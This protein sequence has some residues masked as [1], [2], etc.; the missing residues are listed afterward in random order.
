M[1]VATLLFKILMFQILASFVAYSITIQSF[2]HDVRHCRPC[3]VQDRAHGT[4]DT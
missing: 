3:H 4:L 1:D 2:S